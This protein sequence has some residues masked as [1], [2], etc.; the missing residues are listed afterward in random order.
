MRE[1]EGEIGFGRFCEMFLGRVQ[2]LRIGGDVTEN[3]DQAGA[4][5]RVFQ[6]QADTAQDKFFGL[7]KPFRE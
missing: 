3:V 1:C 4:S 7:G 6:V 5:S 2:G